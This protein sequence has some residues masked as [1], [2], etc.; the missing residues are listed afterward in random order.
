MLM[1]F[2]LNLKG[3]DDDW[4]DFGGFEVSMLK[5][6]SCYL[7]SLKHHNELFVEIIHESLIL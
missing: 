3:N 4:A 6:F 7:D 2:V 5:R 1:L